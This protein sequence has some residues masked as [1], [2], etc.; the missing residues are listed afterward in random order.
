MQEREG[1]VVRS[2]GKWCEVLSGDEV[3]NCQIR[4]KFRMEGIRT[5][6]PVAVGD[7]VSFTMSED[8]TGVVSQIHDRKNYIVRK[9]VNLSK[10][11]HIVASNIDRAFLVVTMVQP[12]TS[13]GFI[14]RFL[15][16]ADAYGVPVTLLFNKVDIYDEN[17]LELLQYYEYIYHTCGYESLRI[18][19]KDGDGLAEVKAAMQEGVNLLSGH[20]GVGKSTLINQLVPGAAVKTADVSSFHQKGQHTTTF[21][22]MHHLPD[23]GFIVD[24]P[25]IKGFGLVDLPKDEL[26]HHFPEMF[27]LL[28]ECKFHNCKHVNE[29][30]CAVLQA[31]ED[32]ELPEERYANYR[33]M[34]EE[35][36]GGYR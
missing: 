17:A 29:P 26:H 1:R 5:T 31:I 20:S 3:V 18:S 2:M 24:T 8:G 22:E 25:G 28:P 14:D 11:A 34:L 32:E 21:A 9:S 23:G 4:G 15:V 6:N 36:E 13:T 12:P 7:L 35:E 10:H 16:T 30:G 27:A 33:M 19:A